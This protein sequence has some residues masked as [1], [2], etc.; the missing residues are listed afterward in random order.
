M[1]ARRTL[2]PKPR[3]CSSAKVPEPSPAASRLYTIPPSAPF[4]TTLARA[5]LAGDLP[6]A[7]RTP[8]PIR[9]LCRSPP[10][11]CRPAARRGRCARRSSPEAKGEALLLPRIRALGDPDEDAAIIFGAE[12]ESRG[13]G[14]I[15]AAGDRR[16][17]AAAGADAARARLRAPA[18]RS[19]RDRARS[20]TASAVVDVT[21]D[22]PL[23]LPPTSP[24]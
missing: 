4:L 14:A 12:D 6:L 21:P 8:S 11:I 13:D 23:I 9:S 24:A 18:S 20:S 1:S 5:M 2:W 7:R 19:R 16:A 17:A 22:K 10:S 3:P 15:G